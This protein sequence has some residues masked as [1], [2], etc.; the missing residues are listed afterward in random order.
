ML[1]AMNQN[2]RSTG[3]VVKSE[4]KSTIDNQRSPFGCGILNTWGK[5][6]L[7]NLWGSDHSQ[8]SFSSY[9][10]H[11]QPRLQFHHCLWHPW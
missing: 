10:S 4:K 2:M 9:S 7:G 8:G 5:I 1:D 3:T 6:L 11:S